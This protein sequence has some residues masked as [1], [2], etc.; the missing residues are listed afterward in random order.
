M[1]IGFSSS[2][3]G[4]Y[5]FESYVICQLNC[6]FYQRSEAIQLH[7][8]RLNFLG[9][10]TPS[11]IIKVRMEGLSLSLMDNYLSHFS[12][13][14]KPAI[15]TAN[16]LSDLDAEIGITHVYT[17]PPAANGNG[18]VPDLFTGST[19]GLSATLT[20]P[21]LLEASKKQLDLIATISVELLNQFGIPFSLVS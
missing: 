21:L 20:K 11:P 15:P 9:A 16:F 1:Y 10:T 5:F 8:S 6:Y 4:M 17:Y 2:F 3:L 13:P 19:L 14:H 7:L 18:H 12:R